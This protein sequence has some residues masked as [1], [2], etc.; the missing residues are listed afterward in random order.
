MKNIYRFLKIF[1]LPLLTYAIFF[2]FRLFGTP[3][4]NDLG[5]MHAFMGAVFI[6]FG[7]SICYL[8]TILPCCDFYKTVPRL[9]SRFWILSTMF[10]YLLLGDAAFRIHEN[11]GPYLGRETY[12]FAIYGIL[13]LIIVVF[14]WKSFQ[15]PFWYFFIC[16]V[17]FSGIAVIGDS[18]ARHEGIIVIASQEI[19][20]EQFCETFSMLL[21]ASGFASEAIHDLTVAFKDK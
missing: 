21:L 9:K 20:Y 13:L 11:L 14:Y 3:P 5:G 6:M 8:M 18:S 17:V 10:F 16:F 1:Y 2:A 7:C 15:R 4:R 19:S 12:V